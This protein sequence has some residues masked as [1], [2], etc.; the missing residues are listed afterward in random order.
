M[1][2]HWCFV[3]QSSSGDYLPLK[4]TQRSFVVAY[5]ESNYVLLFCRGS[6]LQLYIHK[7]LQRH[8]R[9]LQTLKLQD[10][11][12]CEWRDSV[13]W[14]YWYHWYQH[15]IRSCTEAYSDWCN[16]ASP[17]PPTPVGQPVPLIS[18]PAITVTAKMFLHLLPPPTEHL[19]CNALTAWVHDSCFQTN[20]TTIYFMVEN[21]CKQP[22]SSLHQH[23]SKHFTEITRGCPMEGSTVCLPLNAAPWCFHH[24]AVWRTRL[25]TSPLSPH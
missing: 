14:C 21:W 6:N 17:P 1:Q 20:P 9:T 13:E 3:L 16:D 15:G 4:Q 24:F 10:I 5:Y 8:K 18:N 25:P 19:Q 23:Y 22:R 12:P 11:G 2:V 7:Q